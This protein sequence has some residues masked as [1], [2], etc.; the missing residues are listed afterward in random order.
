MVT[1]GVRQNLGSRTFLLLLSRKTT[2]A[3]VLL[4][5]SIILFSAD[6]SLALGL[7][8][9]MSLG[10]TIS[11]ATASSIAGA[12]AYISLLLFLLA[13]IAFLIGF[14]VALLQY[15]NYTFTLDEFGVKMHR[16][17]FSQREISVP[18]RQIQDVDI[19]RNIPHRL[20]GVSKLVMITAG[21]ED[22]GQES[23]GTDTV[24]DPIDKDLA[25]EIRTFMERK[26]GVQ[27]IEGTVQADTEEKVEEKSPQ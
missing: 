10:G 15:R 2:I 6:N 9:L 22:K 23:D 16:G 8:G 20:F 24:F 5:I 11:V 4:L 14:I 19:I 25:E 1:I 18:Y 17:I 3:F 12:I 21:H 26:R 27:I 13:V 7:A